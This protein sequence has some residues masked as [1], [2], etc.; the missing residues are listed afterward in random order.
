V[1]GDGGSPRLLVVDDDAAVATST[2][3]LL[4]RSG[5]TVEV[6]GSGRDA[7]ALCARSA[8]DLMLLD[9]DMPDMDALD[10]LD[11]L[12][13]GDAPPPFPVLIFTGARLSTADQVLGLEAGARD[14]IAKGSNR[15]VLV[16]RIRSALRDRA[17]PAVLQKGELRIDVGAGRAS[18]AGRQLDVDRTPLQV[19]QHLAAREGQVVTK[20]ELLA[21][22]WGTEYTGL[23]HAVEQAVYALRVA[24]G[25]RG[26]I[27]TVHRRGYRFV[28][29]R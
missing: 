8:P 17:R 10:V 11:A 7:V 2:A 13:D 28:T 22:V 25:E 23:D 20:S 4:K 3:E 29:L 24:L 12:R 14:Y 21:D 9:Y 26:W 5:Y 16:A 15:Q 27:E 19:L 6:A 1:A 18:L